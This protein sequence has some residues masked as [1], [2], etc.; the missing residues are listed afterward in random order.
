[1]SDCMLSIITAAA[2]FNTLPM[3]SF[4]TTIPRNSS[5]ATTVLLITK[6]C[7]TTVRIDARIAAKISEHFRC[8][9]MFAQHEVHNRVL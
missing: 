3:V 2:C 5:L 4:T 7:S 6:R 8:E 1:M 9:I